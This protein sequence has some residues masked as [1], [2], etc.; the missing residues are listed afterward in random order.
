[1]TDPEAGD[2]L[3]YLHCEELDGNLEE[4]V[5]LPILDE[6]YAA[7]VDCLSGLRAE[8]EWISISS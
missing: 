3:E 1:M 4:R 8:L 2:F 6:P 7:E 5:S